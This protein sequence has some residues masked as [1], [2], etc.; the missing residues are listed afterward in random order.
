MPHGINSHQIPTYTLFSLFFLWGPSLLYSNHQP[1]N[2][3]C[4]L[5]LLL[6][7]EDPSTHTPPVEPR[8]LQ[9]RPPLPPPAVVACCWLDSFK[10][11]FYSGSGWLL[12]RVLVWPRSATNYSRRSRGGCRPPPLITC[13]RMCVCVSYM[14]RGERR[15]VAFVTRLSLPSPGEERR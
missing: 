11:C 1:T 9:P 13:V 15:G 4:S 3:S 8:H 2:Q 14:L 12:F 10:P 7:P 6:Q 5:L